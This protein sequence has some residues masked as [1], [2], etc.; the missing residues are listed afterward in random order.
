MHPLEPE[1]R[2][3]PPRVVAADL[4]GTLLPLLLDST[5]ALTPAT[6]AAVRILR[7]MGIVVILATGRMFRSAAR[8][9]TN[10]GLAG[11]VAAY[12]GALIREVGTGRLIHHDPISLEM[13]QEILALLEPRGLTVNLYIDDELYVAAKNT[14]TER[15]E[16]LSGIRAHSVGSLSTFL[17]R[18]TT[19]I[20][21]SGEPAVI[22]AL[23]DEIR[24]S[25]EKRIS[26]LK[27]WPFF[28]E[29]ASPT[30]TKGRALQMLGGLLGFEAS[31][32]LAFGDSYNDVD[33]LAWAGT[34]VAMTGAPPEVLAVADVVCES[35][36]DDGFAHHLMRQPWFP[37]EHLRTARVEP[38]I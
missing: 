7:E 4:D 9:A 19:K 28:L 1:Y 23:L 14:D 17:D 18:P 15:Y 30:A 2:L 31:D 12:Q 34:G 27:T 32:V 25:Y 16:S 11:P 6:V 24:S 5:Q 33:M 29:L 38:N 26:A 8:F 20:G 35:V 37:Q 13:A 22:D 3:D 21:V 36:D 10:L